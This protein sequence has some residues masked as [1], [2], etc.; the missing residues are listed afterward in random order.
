M[1]GH[2]PRPQIPK[3]SSPKSGLRCPVTKIKHIA[4]WSNDINPGCLVPSLKVKVGTRIL[5]P[6]NFALHRQIATLHYVLVLFSLL[7]VLPFRS[8]PIGRCSFIAVKHWTNGL[9]HRVLWYQIPSMN[10]ARGLCSRA[11]YDEWARF[12]LHMSRLSPLPP[13]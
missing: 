13:D 10:Q 1:T 6:W 4:K 2:H 11:I 5:T 7:T 8:W 9:A 12:T 3:L